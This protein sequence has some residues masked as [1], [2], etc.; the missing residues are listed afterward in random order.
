MVYLALNKRR[1][2]RNNPQSARF[3]LD[4]MGEVELLYNGSGHHLRCQV[5]G[6]MRVVG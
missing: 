6:A 1:L 2:T 5:E 3:R 4:W